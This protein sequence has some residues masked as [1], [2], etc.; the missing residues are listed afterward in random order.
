[1]KKIIS[2]ILAVLMV[3]SV[4]AMAVSAADE[5][6]KPIKITF[7]YDSADSNGKA[8]EAEKVIYVDYGEDYNKEAP[9]DTYIDGGF[10]Y[11]I[12][13][14]ETEDYGPKNY[15][16]TSLPVVPATD[17]QIKEIKFRACY[18][19]EKVT[20]GGVVEDAAESL[21]G[22]S[23]VEFFNYIVKQLELWFGQFILFLRNFL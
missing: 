10:K 3:F 8:V 16:H 19:V 5:T 14:W 6:T 1:M 4:T 20:P 21:L 11:F 12:S 2:L 15:I 23:T 9:K 13:G 18:D 22:E 17:T 7:V